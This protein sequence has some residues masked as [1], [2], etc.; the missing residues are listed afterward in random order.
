LIYFDAKLDRHRPKGRRAPKG[1]DIRK[2]AMNARL[3][4]LTKAGDLGETMKFFY[5]P[6]KIKSLVYADSPLLDILSRR[7]LA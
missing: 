3:R 6:S 7:P 4:A 2:Q 5:P 1:K